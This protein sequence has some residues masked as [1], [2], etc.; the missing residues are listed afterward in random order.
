[1]NLDEDIKFAVLFRLINTDVEIPVFFPV[2]PMIGR[3]SEDNNVFTDILTGKKTISVSEVA[4][5]NEE[6][7][8]GVLTDV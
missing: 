8:F 7:C 4:G 1:M 6:E 5:V 3:L 2:K